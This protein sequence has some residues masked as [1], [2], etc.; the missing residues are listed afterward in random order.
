M[1]RSSFFGKNLKHGENNENR[2]FWL[3]II[4]A[5]KLFSDA[6][7]EQFYLV[8]EK[9]FKR[10]HTRINIWYC[11]YIVKGKFLIGKWGEGKLFSV[12]NLKCEFIYEVR[13]VEV[14]FFIFD[15]ELF[16]RVQEFDSDYFAVFVQINEEIIADFDCFVYFGIFDIGF[17]VT[18]I[19]FDI[20]F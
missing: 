2:G 5:N 20:D 10:T 17:K 8:R 4:C 7:K 11:V 9:I 15:A 19:F 12:F 18:Y 1:L 14:C 3:Y 16:E 6:K 13:G